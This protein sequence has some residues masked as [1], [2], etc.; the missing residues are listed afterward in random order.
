MMTKSIP[1]ITMPPADYC[2]LLSLVL[3]EPLLCFQV[4][5]SFSIFFSPFHFSFIHSVSVHLKDGNK[6]LIYAQSEAT[7]KEIGKSEV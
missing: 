7:G 4:S 5:N 1:K 2:R 3:F 6:E